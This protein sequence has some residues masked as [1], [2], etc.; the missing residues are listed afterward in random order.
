MTQ[1]F[2]GNETAGKMIS[3]VLETGN[4]S[5]AYLIYGEQGLGKKTFARL[6]AMGLLCS[7]A[8]KPCGD[9][10]SCR[11]IRN[12]THPDVM[13]YEEGTERN[14]LHIDLIRKIRADCSVPPNEGNY[15]V[16]I[17]AN[18]QNMT[19]GAANAF[20]KTLEEPPKHAV[21]LLTAPGTAQLPQTVLS[22]LMPVQLYPVAPQLVAEAL[23]QK[24]PEMEQARL[25]QAARLADGNIG[26][27]VR[28]VTDAG[29]DQIL[30][31]LDKLCGC[32][33]VN[34]E[35]DLLCLLNGY[36]KNKQGLTV[37][38]GQLTH[39]LRRAVRHKLQLGEPGD[40]QAGGLAESLTK[41]QLFALISFL[42]DARQRLT[43]NAHYNLLTA[44]IC[45]G[46]K[47]RLD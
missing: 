26:Q 31:D 10:P 39:V 21:F 1:K 32:L 27:A 33:V 24:F 46:M 22:R 18:A 20:L 5:H 25:L 28:I 29:F 2:Y 6:F 17:L 7:S 45:A 13:V 40:K 8:H 12:G 34:R 30:L 16:Y 37:L 11:K 47:K 19:P 3:H 41:G 42:E 23:Q 43:T 36:E 9:C 35:Y 44:Y 4:V 38:L 14:S 15:K